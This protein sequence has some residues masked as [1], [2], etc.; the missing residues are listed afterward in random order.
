MNIGIRA[1]SST[2]NPASASRLP[3]PTSHLLTPSLLGSRTPA[4]TGLI[5]GAAGHA[6]CFSEIAD[7]S[8]E[9]QHSLPLTIR[10]AMF[11]QV[12]ALRA[13]N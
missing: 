7:L 1:F 8:L 6:R 12:R 5:Q 13:F 4:A 2:G 10:W 3:A 9:V 11:P